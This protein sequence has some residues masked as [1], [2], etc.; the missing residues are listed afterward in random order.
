MLSTVYRNEDIVELAKACEHLKNVRA[1]LVAMKEEGTIV[2][3]DVRFIDLLSEE[4]Q[5]LTPKNR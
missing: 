2:P 1:N 3:D 5:S 4:I